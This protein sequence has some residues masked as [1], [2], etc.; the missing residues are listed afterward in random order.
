MKAILPE[1]LTYI[2][3]VGILRTA[4]IRYMSHT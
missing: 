3:K 1:L 2:K 4:P